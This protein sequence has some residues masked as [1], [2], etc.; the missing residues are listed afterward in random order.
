MRRISAY[1]LAAEILYIASLWL[2]TSA[3]AANS[4]DGSVGTELEEVVVTATKREE[5]IEKVPAS[6]VTFSDNRF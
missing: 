6:I 1:G 5:N 3:T 2:D 4:A